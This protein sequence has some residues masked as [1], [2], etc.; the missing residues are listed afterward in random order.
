MCG[1]AGLVLRDPQALP[2]KD[3]VLGMAGRIAHRGPDG[4]GLHLAQGVALAHRRLA[5]IDLADTGKQPM[6]DATGRYTIVFNGEIYN[7]KDLRSELEAA[8]RNFR[9]QS[10]TE[11]ILNGYAAWGN[12]VL[13]KLRGMFTFALWDM[14]KA[15]LLLARD[16]IGKK[17]L[18]YGTLP[19]GDIAFASE[20]K[21]LPPIIHNGLD[22]GAIRLFLGL[23]YVPTPRTG[24]LGISQLEP[25]SYALCKNGTMKVQRY[26]SYDLPKAADMLNASDDEIASRIREMLEEAVKLRMMASDVPVGAFLSGGVDSAAVVALT[27]AYRGSAPFH[28]FSMG[29]PSPKMDERAEARALAAHFGT[30]HQEFEARPE[31][32]LRLVDDLVRQYDMPY[33]DSS[34]LP[35]WLLSEQTAKHIKVV[36]TGDGGDELFG[37]YRRYAAYARALSL[38]K[39]PLAGCAPGLLTAVARATRD[40]RFHRMGELLATLHA[41]PSRAYGELFCGSYFG[42]R[43]MTELLQP[44]FADA[45]SSDDAVSF[46]AGR[47]GG[48]TSLEAAMHFDLTSY[49]PD[50]LNVKMDRATMRFG[51]EARSPFLDQE[52]I[53]YALRIQASRKVAGGQTKAILKK[54]LKGL[55]PDEV[56]TRPK[57]GFQVPL[58][59][60]FRGPMRQ[61]FEERCCGADSELSLYIRPKAA[62]NL[63]AENASGHD[64]GNRL[65]MLLSLA[66]WLQH[67]HI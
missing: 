36:L 46:V 3:L 10:D 33:A 50:D 52:L 20:I 35:L 4:E 9:T 40:L 61:T 23:Q 31:D 13:S 51:L 39:L 54:A 18:Y 44:D 49:L 37:G 66:T 48:N 32:M 64:H 6:Q 65:W 12:K 16:R 1:I 7:Y 29:F 60:W 15:E 8:G 27:S 41:D 47:M 62:Q 21:A 22:H 45:T 58:A 30:T 25:G 5:I 56:L 28:T 17:P 63:L 24:L 14:Q 53:S 11:V 57:R 2:A 55:V 19:S 67:T 59:E 42:T 38:A 43:G 34:A 26:H